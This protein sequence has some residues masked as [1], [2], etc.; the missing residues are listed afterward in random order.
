MFV[1]PGLLHARANQCG[2]AGEHAQFGADHLSR[3]PLAVG[4]FGDF[5]AAESFHGA[6]TLA[7]AGHTKALQAHQGILG[8]VGSKAHHA[9]RGF[10]RMDEGNAAALRAVRCSSGT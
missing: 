2:R 8:S 10:T 5:P 6:V 1:E 9:A 4:M 3:G 7:H